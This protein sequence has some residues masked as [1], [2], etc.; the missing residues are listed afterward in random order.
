MISDES[1]A[2]NWCAVDGNISV[3]MSKY[4]DDSLLSAFMFNTFANLLSSKMSMTYNDIV[5]TDNGI[6]STAI[7][8]NLSTD[9]LCN[10]FE[11]H[12]SSSEEMLA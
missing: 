5:S 1:Y 6:A 12:S 2:D 9:I 11:L 4:I 7:Y 10:D 8:K 3:S